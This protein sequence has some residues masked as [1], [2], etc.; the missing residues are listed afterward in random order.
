M[1][2]VVVRSLL[3]AAS[4]AGLWACGALAVRG[5]HGDARGVVERGSLEEIRDKRAMMLVVGRSFSVDARAPA[6]VSD[7]DVLTA[8]E[9]ARPRHSLSAYRL[10]G[11]RLNGYIR[12]YHSMTSVESRD[13]ADF[14]VVFKIMEE[15]HSLIDGR[16]ITYG[17]LFVVTR[18][19]GGALRLVWESRGEMSIDDD[20]AGQFIRALK[21]VRGEQ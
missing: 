2:G 9:T 15:R 4:L 20:A 5:Q 13:D 11:A 3:I 6:E 21:Q 19:A 14:F 17:K 8:M 12:K 18:G 16:P 1:N 7:E 10:I